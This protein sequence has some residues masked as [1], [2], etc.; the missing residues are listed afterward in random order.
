[1]TSR[2]T[3][4]STAITSFPA[5]VAVATFAVFSVTIAALGL[6]PLAT[7]ALVPV[8]ALVTYGIA[9]KARGVPPTLAGVQGRAPR[10]PG[11][12]PRYQLVAMPVNHFGEKLR[13]C[14]DLLGVPYEE[15]TVG[16]ILSVVLR[17]R[18]VP[19]LVDRQTCSL[20][21]NSDEALWYLSAVHVPLMEGAA[22]EHALALLRRDPG[23]MAWESR[24][25]AVGHAVQG[26]AYYYLVGKG[27]DPE[28]S[29]R[30]WGGREPEVPWLHRLAI[31]LGHPI[32]EQGMRRAFAL[33]DEALMQKR[34]G[35]ITSLLDDA[36]AA[37][38]RNGGRYLTGD[39]L[40]YVDVAFA[41]LIGPLLST[42]VLPHWAGGRFT[43]F[44][45]LAGHPGTPRELVDFEQ[46]LRARPAGQHVERL[47]RDWRGHR[48][49]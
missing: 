13:W 47:F 1:M 6:S 16:G 20:L 21:G 28:L 15:S 11:G 25:N 31:R 12:L 30:F 40:S 39:S 19:W 17:G 42:T 8:P 18:S 27:A 41:A 4:A 48:F 7:L 5:L 38:A 23:T 9:R 2:R 33:H 34:L 36:D 3:R 43:S 46:A 10:A 35:I 26:W 32:L 14:L 44:A 49:G 24:L 29:L 22:R 45:P 37:L